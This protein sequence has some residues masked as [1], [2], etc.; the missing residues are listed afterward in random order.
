[1]TQQVLYSTANGEI[2]QWQD[3][4][5]FS[6]AEPL[7]GTATLAVTAAQWETQ[8]TAQ[9]VSN[10]ALVPGSA[11]AIA[12]VLTLA[13]QAAAASIAG[14]TIATAAGSVT[15]TMAATKFPTDAETQG[16][17]N[18][19]V[20]GLNTNGTFPEGAAT[21]PMIDA[22]TPP[23]WHTFT[24]AQYKAVATAIFNYVSAN[25]L[26]AA[27]NPLGATTLPANSVTI[28]V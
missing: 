10:D 9:Y 12:P 27:G 25:D 19:V 1:V 28:S 18:T 3:T 14:L 8:G 17:L 22:A 11:P 2:I 24:V 13:Q 21:F 23:V 20:N 16:I 15:L 6:F 26:I 4:S 5:L 7:T